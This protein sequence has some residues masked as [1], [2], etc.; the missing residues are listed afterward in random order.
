MSTTRYEAVIGLEI[1][2]QLDTASKAFSDAPNAYGARPNS[3]VAEVDL[4][5]PGA[6]PVLN[7]RAVELA[8]RAGLGLGCR[9]EP[10]SQFA[11]KNYFYADLPKGYQISQHTLPLCLDGGVVIDLEDGTTRRIGVERV[12]ME[13]DAGK[14]IHLGDVPYSIVD[15]N[16]AG[17]PLIEIVSRP[18][19]RSPDEAVAYMKAVHAIVVA[20]GVCDGNM[21]EGS[22]RCD[23]NVSIRPVGQRAL[24]TRA[25]IKNVN[26]FKFV[27]DALAYEIT[28][29]AALLD[30]GEA[31][32][33]Q[34]RTYNPE[35]GET[36]AL[37]SKEEA[38]DYRYFPEPDLP[39]LIIAPETIA[40]IAETMPELPRARRERYERA[41]G[42]SAYDA[43][44]LASDVQ[45]AEYFEAA[46]NA[47]PDA[48]ALAKPLANWVINDV[49]REI[50][51]PRG[52]EALKV[53]PAQLAALVTLLA[54][55]TIN[56]RAAKDVFALMLETGDDPQAIVTA[57]GL[58][59]ITDED[60]IAALVAETIRAHPEQVATYRA[61]RHGLL[62]FFIGQV[63]QASRGKA[64]PQR[65]RALVSAALDGDAEG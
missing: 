14:S 29:Q 25:E 40:R 16:R 5:L 61:G 62:G 15:L 50:K 59:Q 10:L 41:L 58:R 55:D 30:A 23:A 39:P 12:H 47:L 19:L 26:S 38:H 24:G 49:L 7:A 35:L 13:E 56:G 52:L 46:L 28:R 51:G 9:I 37:R 11:R 34:T 54:E 57:R 42:L 60:A 53:T 6:L 4:G 45:V 44:V 8:I 21:E 2:C 31:V 1:H 32:V 36:V 65:V 20:L 27:R 63:M 64:N 3:Q 33:Q 18:E 43:A 22:F 17:V 48:E